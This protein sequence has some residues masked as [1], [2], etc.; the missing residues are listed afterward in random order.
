MSE[1]N[2]EFPAPGMGMARCIECGDLACHPTE[3]EQTEMQTV[4]VWKVELR[5]GNCETRRVDFFQ[6]D[7]CDGFDHWLDDCLWTIQAN[8]RALLR[9]NMSWYVDKWVDALEADAIMPMDF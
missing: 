4:D 8:Y 1:I 7:E 3:I 6:Q 2:H 5:C 9:D